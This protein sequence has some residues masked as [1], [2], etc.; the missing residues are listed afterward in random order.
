M[1]WHHCRLL[2]GLSKELVFRCLP[3]DILR[4]NHVPAFGRRSC[5]LEQEP[6]AAHEEYATR[7]RMKLQRTDIHNRLHRNTS[8]SSRFCAA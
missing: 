5:T 1:R 8:L 3:G 7:F 6:I 2:T 4:E